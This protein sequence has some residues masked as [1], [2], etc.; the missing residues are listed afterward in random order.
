[1][2]FGAYVVYYF[3]Q[4]LYFLEHLKG[5]RQAHYDIKREELTFE[6]YTRVPKKYTKNF[7]KH[8][9][10]YSEYE[11][12][13]HSR[14]WHGVQAIFGLMLLIGLLFPVWHFSGT[15]DHAFFSPDVKL[16]YDSKGYD[17][18]IKMVK[19]AILIFAWCCA[20]ISFKIT[21]KIKK[22]LDEFYYNTKSSTS[23]LQ[24]FILNARYYRNNFIAYMVISLFVYYMLWI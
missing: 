20:V 5:F 8:K 11:Q 22:S 12:Q 9:H 17:F 15:Y 23:E 2:A 3:W 14:F 18:F 24:D 4:I 13:A 16:V 21:N 19:A 1:M 6:R 7:R 10:E